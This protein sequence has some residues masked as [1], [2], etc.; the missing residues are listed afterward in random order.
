MELL[1]NFSLLSKDRKNLHARGFSDEVIDKYKFK[2]CHPINHFILQKMQVQMGLDKMLKYGLFEPDPNHQ[3]FYS[4]QWQLV[5]SNVLIPYHHSSKSITKIRPHK[6]GFKGSGATV[7]RTFASFRPAKVCVIAESEF[8]AVAAECFGFSAIGIP[9]ITS[10]SRKNWDY[11]ERELATIDTGDFIICFDNEIKGDPLLKKFK[12]DW[13]KRYD[14]IIYAYAMAQKILN[15]GRNCRI[16]TLPAEWMV[17]GK[18]DIDQ[19]LALGKQPS[20][21]ERIILGAV[22]PK[23]FLDQ[24]AIPEKH[25]PFVGRSVG[26]FFYIPQI[27]VKGHC[28]Y[29]KDK[30]GEDGEVEPGIQLTNCELKIKNIYEEVGT[31]TDGMLRDIVIT[32][33]FNID[34][35]AV[36]IKPVSMASKFGFKTW[37]MSQGN[38]IFYGGDDELTTIWEYIFNTDEANIVYLLPKCGY[39]KEFDF[40]IFKNVLIKNQ[41]AIYPDD[42]GI[43]WLDEV[44]YKAQEIHEEN[45]VPSLETE[46]PFDIKKFMEYLSNTVDVKDF[47]M[48]KALMAWFLAVLFLEDIHKTFKLFPILFLYGHRSSGKTTVMRWLLSFFGQG[49]AMLSLSRSSMVGVNRGLSYFSGLPF[50]TDDWRNSHELKQYINTFLGV[51]NRQSGIKGRKSRFGIQ[52]NAVRAALC[53]MGEELFNDNALMSRCIAMYMPQTRIKECSLDMEDIIPTASNFFF[54]LLTENYS[55]MSAN[56]IKNI[57]N[58]HKKFRAGV[59][60]LDARISIN[61]AILVGAYTTVFGEDKDLID[62][63]YLL[64]GHRNEAMTDG[65]K[66]H[67]FAEEFI[68][69]IS[70]YKVNEV[71]YFFEDNCIFLWLKGICDTLNIYYGRK[72]QDNSAL[73]IQH[74]KKQPYFVKS[75]RRHANKHGS[76]DLPFIALDLNLMPDGLKASFESAKKQ[77]EVFARKNSWNL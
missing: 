25:R 73:L 60:G 8:K 45:P 54:K 53:V 51:Y 28:F 68:V 74:F 17:D 38:Y 24:S 67:T 22:D 2:S 13:R 43:F 15:T 48:S 11:F 75:V 44:G 59:K 65:D 7:F 3:G 40:F 71:H 42:N 49:Q 64:M 21:F 6:L 37:L 58:Y 66:I 39:V 70:N 76:M 9:G 23:T 30:P 34:S 27:D 18:I 46:K 47:A 35:K 41:K 72:D 77:E 33:E 29:S 55:E 10:M 31:D 32:N 69:C 36:S 14:T 5:S 56:I 1:E 52:V 57:T 4:P 20:E 16:A 50:V 26:R 63:I 19:A 12:A 61:F 62:Y